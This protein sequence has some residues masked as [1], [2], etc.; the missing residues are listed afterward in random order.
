MIHLH[1]LYFHRLNEWRESREARRGESEFSFRIVPL[2]SGVEMEQQALFELSLKF[3][4]YK[5]YL[6][7]FKK[8]PLAKIKELWTYDAET[9]AWK[10]SR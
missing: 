3:Q 10:A 1:I 5:I 6:F 8:G 7:N 4:K 2:C 9:A